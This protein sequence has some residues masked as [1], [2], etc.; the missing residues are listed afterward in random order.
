MYHIVDMQIMFFILPTVLYMDYVH[1][2]LPLLCWQLI[3]T[4]TLFPQGTL[5]KQ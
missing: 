5:F 1:F 4:H 2:S 3:Y